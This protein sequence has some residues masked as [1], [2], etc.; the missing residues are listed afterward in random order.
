MRILTIRRRP[1]KNLRLILSH[2]HGGTLPTT[3]H[4]VK[5]KPKE[6][7]RN[8]DSF[9]PHK[10]TTSFQFHHFLFLITISKNTSWMM[11]VSI[12]NLNC[13]CCSCINLMHNFLNT[14]SHCNFFTC[15]ICCIALPKH[16]YFL[17]RHPLC[18]HSKHIFQQCCP[19]ARIALLIIIKMHWWEK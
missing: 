4:H 17:A 16:V 10:T 8:G 7:K 1:F 5:L 12:W 18:L 2:P 9:S 15:V 13:F 6:S 11:P 19:S 3:H 14:L